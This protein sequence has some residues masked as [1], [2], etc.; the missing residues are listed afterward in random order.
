MRA[1]KKKQFFILLILG[2]ILLSLPWFKGFSGVILFIALLPILSVERVLY[3]Q[4]DAHKSGQVFLYAFFSFI[5]WNILTTYWIYNAT[6]FGAFAAVLINSFLMSFTFWLFH[7]THRKLGHRFGYFSLMAYWTGFEYIYLNVQVSWPWLNLGNGFAKDLPLIQWYEFTGATSA[8]PWILIINILFFGLLWE[9]V[10]HGSLKNKIFEMV[11]LLILIIAPISYSVIRFHN[12]KEKGTPYEAVVVQPNIDPYNEKFSGMTNAEQ[13]SIILHLADSLTGPTTDFVVAPETS[14]DDN[15]LEN[16]LVTNRSIRRI[17]AFVNQHPRVK[18]ITGMVSYYFFNPHETL[19]KT[20]REYVKDG[21]YY[22]SYNA[23]IEV[24]STGRYQVYH[25]SKLVIGV[26]MVPF[27]GL[28]KKFKN[29][30]IDLGGATGSYGTQKE[31]SLLIAPDGKARVGTAICYESVYGEY[32]TEY[33]KKGANLIF[34]VT[35]DGWWGHTSGY[36]QHLTYSSLRAI[37]TRRSIARSA[38][39]GISCFINQKGVIRQATAWWEP[40]V[41]KGIIHAN[42]AETFYVKHGDFISRISLFFGI[43]VLLYTLSVTLISRKRKT[44]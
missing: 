16:Q 22:D 28:M 44:H 19:S 33:I 30:I 3:E 31:R 23:S 25:K 20:A 24:D 21:K 36:R 6:L 17:Q 38:N 27:P 29:L 11:V 35:N 43:L 13:L 12:Y 14:I 41:I 9:Y 8:T 40:A 42:N 1:F 37:E 39:T 2:S 10:S 34:V 32:V 4:R 15:I 18:F 5:I 7:I 26:E